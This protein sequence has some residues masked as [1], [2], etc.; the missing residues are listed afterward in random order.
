MA[1]LLEDQKENSPSCKDDKNWCI[2]GVFI[3]SSNQAQLIYKREF[4]KL[5]A[6]QGL[7]FTYCPMCGRK[8][9]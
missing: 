8:L 7:V 6:F 4:M 5:T 9:E 3:P 2:Q 1:S